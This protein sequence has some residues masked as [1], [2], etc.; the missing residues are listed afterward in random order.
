MDNDQPVQFKLPEGFALP[1]STRPQTCW[2]KASPL[3]EEIRRK[4]LLAMSA[5]QRRAAISSV[6]SFDSHFV[7]PL[8]TSGLVE[9]YRKLA[10]S[11]GK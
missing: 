5:E 2:Q 8:K 11:V 1:T 3:L 6:F 7:N 4:E 10:R 9:Y